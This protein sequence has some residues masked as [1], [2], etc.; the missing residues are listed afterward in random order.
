MSTEPIID[1]TDDEFATFVEVLCV[2]HVHGHATDSHFEIKTRR[3]D[4]LL[5]VKTAT[6]R[7]LLR[8]ALRRI[9]DNPNHSPNQ[10][11]T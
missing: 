9:K 10:G 11:N 6:T 7:D 3:R 4:G 2:Q 8:W 1:L 5:T